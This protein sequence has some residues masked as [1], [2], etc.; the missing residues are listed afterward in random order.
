M[1]ATQE[2][3]Q[4]HV[5]AWQTSG[6][7]TKAYAAAHGLR[8]NT[9]SWWRPSASAGLVQVGKLVDGQLIV[10][11]GRVTV[12]FATLG[13]TV[14]CEADADPRCVAMVLAAL[15]AQARPL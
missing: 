15:A 10:A 2:K 3:W 7:T 5:R 13:A 14:A 12:T 1:T 11:R 4:R 8:A 6:A 9:L